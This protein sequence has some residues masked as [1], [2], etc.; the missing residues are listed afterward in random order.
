MVCR[1][2]KSTKVKKGV[3]K[4]DL[5]ATP[6]IDRLVLTMK[7]VFYLLKYFKRFFMTLPD[8]KELQISEMYNDGEE[9]D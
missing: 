3:S 2:I 8:T 9:K 4:I 6:S 7:E 5:F 1:L